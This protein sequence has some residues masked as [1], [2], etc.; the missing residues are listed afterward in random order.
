MSM[1][2]N[3]KGVIKKKSFKIMSKKYSKKIKLSKKQNKKKEKKKL[4]ISTRKKRGGM[5]EQPTPPQVPKD[6]DV[7]TKQ[8]EPGQ[9]GVQQPPQLPPF[10]LP[11]PANTEPEVRSGS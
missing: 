1:V 7:G 6:N 5:D 3:R 2:S 10:M 9:L 4:R 11:P 8:Y